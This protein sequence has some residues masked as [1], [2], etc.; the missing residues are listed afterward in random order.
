MGA[1][2]DWTKPKSKVTPEKVIE[3]LDVIIDNINQSGGRWTAT[4]HEI[5]E[6]CNE[7]DREEYGSYLQAIDMA[8]KQFGL[9]FEKSGRN[10]RTYSI[11]TG[12]LADF[13]AHKSKLSA[14][15]ETTFE[16]TIACS[17]CSKPTNYT[18]TIKEKK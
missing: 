8:I 9:K 7:K 18:L 12:D 11:D 2:H 16:V 10:G 17:H 15:F 14:T 1:I 6:A 4:I 13:L 5:M 3:V